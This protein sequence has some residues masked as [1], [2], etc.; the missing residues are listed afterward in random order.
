MFVQRARLSSFFVH[1]VLEHKDETPKLPS[2]ISLSLSLPAVFSILV[3]SSRWAV[4]KDVFQ[5][6]NVGCVHHQH[7]IGPKALSRAV[8]A[9]RLTRSMELCSVP[10]SWLV[11]RALLGHRWASFFGDHRSLTTTRRCLGRLVDVQKPRKAWEVEVSYVSYTP[12]T[13]RGSGTP[14]S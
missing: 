4:G 2:A 14:C 13:S 5:P 8:L 1:N 3:S 7:Y 6:L 11:I 12:S 10:W 9:T